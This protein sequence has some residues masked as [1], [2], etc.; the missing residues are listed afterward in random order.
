[1]FIVRHDLLRDPDL[2][3]QFRN[4]QRFNDDVGSACSPVAAASSR[5]RFLVRNYGACRVKPGMSGARSAG[6]KVE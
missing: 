5:R 4:L 3:A 6:F 1:V 2:R